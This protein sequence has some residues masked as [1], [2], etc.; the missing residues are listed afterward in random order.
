MAA[1]AC[2]LTPRHAAWDHVRRC[3]PDLSAAQR[4]LER[5]KADLGTRYQGRPVRW[6]L[7]TCP[8]CSGWYLDRQYVAA[9]RAGRRHH[10]QHD[11]DDGADS[12]RAA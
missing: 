8:V 1:L 6:R 5:T 2:R 9:R 3:N 11:D 4:T 10:H 12:E 7:R